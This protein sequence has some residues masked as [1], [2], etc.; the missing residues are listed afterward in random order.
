MNAPIILAEEVCSSSAS[1]SLEC[2]SSI[3]EGTS[4]AVILT[5]NLFANEWIWMSEWIYRGEWDTRDLYTHGC[6]TS[7]PYSSYS[8]PYSS[9]THPYSSYTLMYFYVGNV[10]L[11]RRADS[12]LA[13]E[14]GYM[15]PYY[16]RIAS[17]L[18]RPPLSKELWGGGR[19]RSRPRGGATPGSRAPTHYLS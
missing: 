1:P 7:H 14:G 11:S 3:S 19:S 2:C 17:T 5:V 9:Y 4:R 12:Y 16:L 8:H 6:N 10:I 13:Q 15:P 18:Q